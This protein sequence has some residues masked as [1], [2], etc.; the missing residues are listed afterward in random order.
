MT[1]LRIT[2]LTLFGFLL[3]CPMPMW[4]DRCTD[5]PL[6]T[7]YKDPILLP[8]YPRPAANYFKVTRVVGPGTDAEYVNASSG[9]FGP[10]QIALYQENGVIGPYAWL[11]VRATVE[12]QPGF[13][14]YVKTIP[15]VTSARVVTTHRFYMNGYLIG[16]PIRQESI[17]SDSAPLNTKTFRKCVEFGSEFLRVARRLKADGIQHVCPPEFAAVK[18]AQDTT[19]PAI[20]EVSIQYDREI[21]LQGAD[22]GGSGIPD[23]AL[24]TLNSLKFLVA[25]SYVQTSGSSSNLSFDAMAP[26]LLFHG[27]LA[28]P[29]LPQSPA[30]GGDVVIPRTDWFESFLYPPSNANTSSSNW[31]KSPFV[32]AKVPVISLSYNDVPLGPRPVTLNGQR[33][34]LPGTIDSTSGPAAAAAEAMRDFGAKYCHFVGHSGG[35]L[36]ARR[37]LL[38]QNKQL[39]EQPANLRTF[40]ALSL[41]TIAS[42]HF[43]SLNADYRVMMDPRRRGT[44]EPGINQTPTEQILSNDRLWSD[45]MYDLRTADAREFTTQNPNPPTARIEN[46]SHTIRYSAIWADANLDDSCRS[47]SPTTS[48]ILGAPPSVSP[49]TRNDL[50]TIYSQY[51]PESVDESI[52]YEPP[53]PD[54]SLW[55]QTPYPVG[56]WLTETLYHRL[57]L[58]DQLQVRDVIVGVG[59]IGISR[60]RILFPPQPTDLRMPNDFNVTR[61]SAVPIVVSAQAG[62]P[63]TPIA[64][65]RA[66]HTTVGVRTTGTLV[67]NLIKGIERGRRES[68]LLQ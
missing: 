34:I 50:P 48:P 66:N 29:N 4:A 14:N 28:G 22:V 35:G 45:L 56:S 13:W 32:A 38:E 37:V 54:A 64:A 12:V 20:N 11:S 30:P 16:E 52:G 26:V 39:N 47:G 27:I 63:F 9:L 21:Y 1:P 40:R 5:G 55:R 46:R 19:C 51:A 42:P 17:L 15:G 18:T 33:R 24:F 36:W 65:I 58:S 6:D 25:D 59:G 23:I 41:T 3:L 68:R 10:A 62:P 67:L 49:C 57:F 31:F 7:T 44:V 60:R 43:G 53:D 2:P 8:G 61:E